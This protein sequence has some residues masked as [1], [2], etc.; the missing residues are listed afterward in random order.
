MARTRAL[1][2]PEL[3]HR[4]TQ[5]VGQRERLLRRRDAPIER[6][7]QPHGHERHVEDAQENL[8]VTQPASHGLGLGGRARAPVQVVAVRE[9]G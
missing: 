8:V 7:G 4:I 5:L 2:G 3:A 1:R 9:L 6:V